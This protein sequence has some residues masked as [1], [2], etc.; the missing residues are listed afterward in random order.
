MKKSCFFFAFSDFYFA[1]QKNVVN[2]V[3]FKY[4]FF[5]SP[6]IK[7]NTD[8]SMPAASTH[9]HSAHSRR[10]RRRKEKRTLVLLRP[11]HLG[12]N[13]LNLLQCCHRLSLWLERFERDFWDVVTVLALSKVKSQRSW[14]EEIRFLWRKCHPRAAAT[15]HRTRTTRVVVVAAV[16]LRRRSPMYFS[17]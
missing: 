11:S 6:N 8:V 17:F 14:D 12:L 13:V 4:I 9:R 3:F 1:P 15:S 10:Q 7:L 2:L 5:P 16:L